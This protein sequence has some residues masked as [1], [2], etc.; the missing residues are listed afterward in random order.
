MKRVFRKILSGITALAV[1]WTNSAYLHTAGV[2]EIDS[3]P[4]IAKQNRLS[5]PSDA[6]VGLS[7]PL[8][9]SIIGQDLR[10]FDD[11]TA[12][13]ASE[14]I[15]ESVAFASTELPA[16]YSLRDAGKITSVKNQGTYGTCWT[17][18]S[19]ASAETSI[20]RYEP[21]VNLSEWHTAFFSYYGEDQMDI[22]DLST[23]DVLQYGGNCFTVANLWAQWKGPVIDSKLPYG[24]VEMLEDT[25]IREKYASDSDYHLRNAYMFDYAEDGSNRETIN[26]L[27]KQFIYSGSAVDVSFSTNGYYSVTNS[28]YSTTP[29]ILAD[30]SV[31]IAGWD[32]NFSADSFR[33][34]NKPSSDGA[35]LVR[36]SWDTGWGDNGY[37]WISYED[38]SLTEFSVFELDSKEKYSTNYYYD[39]FYPAALMAAD[40]S[41]AEGT[42]SYMANVF[43][44]E[45]TQQIEAVSTYINVPGT[46][47]EVT[48]YTGLRDSADPDSGTASSVTKGSSDITGYITIELDEDVIVNE[49]EA[50]AVCVKLVS[51]ESAYVLPHEACLVLIDSTTGETTLLT[52]YV[53]YERICENTNTGESFYSGDGDSWT[54]MVEKNQEYTEEEKNELVES[55]ISANADYMTEEDIAA[56]RELFASGDLLMIFGN[57]SVK[58][59]AN[60]V[61]TIDFSHMSGNVPLDEKVSLS[62]KDGSD[63]YYSV[64]GGAEILYTEP[65]TVTE[66][67]KIQA[68]TDHRSYTVREYTPAKAEFIDL[69]YFTTYKYSNGNDIIYAQRV[70]ESEYR[71]NLSGGESSIKLFA[72]SEAD[73]LMNG[74]AMT[75]NEYTENFSAGYGETVI[76]FTLTQENRLD[77]TVTL[78][79]DRSPVSIDIETETVTLNEA[80]QLTAPDGHVFADGESVSEYAGQTL[81]AVVGTETIEV[82]VPERAVLPELEIDYYNETLNFI[83]NN[84]AELTEYA[85]M[86]EPAESDYISAE[87]RFIDGQNITSGKIMNKAFRMIPGET[88]TLRVAPGNGCF[89][90]EAETFVIPKAPQAPTEEPVYSVEGDTIVLEYSDVL[91]YGAYT[92]PLTAEELEDLASDFGYSAEEYTALMLER[93]GITSET[94]LLA[95]L[96]AEWDAVFEYSAS[97]GAVTI[98]VR[99]Y[100]TYDTFASGVKYSELKANTEN[101]IGDS[102]GDGNITAVDAA[103][104]LSY[105]AEKA[106]TGAAELTQ[107]QFERYDYNCDGQITAVDAAMILSTYAENATK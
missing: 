15:T 24:E 87:A 79:I 42:P 53:T 57:M 25:A 52:D 83:P 77:N 46:E 69:G 101:I 9:R 60:P 92:A 16:A 84:T 40:D 19:A 72:V 49:G 37:F 93:Y 103:I 107:E 14:P 74:T 76:E 20:L 21:S 55:I 6:G 33:S 11:L 50:F 12:R 26:E 28:T 36:N 34:T 61:D 102:N 90:S 75:K 99:S 105:Y 94:E 95:L 97:N 13:A 54:D 38:T 44:A 32:D 65:I 82:K 29:P 100:S 64:N 31:T 91:E 22:G 89:G 104:V 45:E 17:F 56:Y 71:I 47:Y 2:S 51:D 35:W 80:E 30:H 41:A 8:F 78:V 5:M 67:M 106:T 23:T 4:V 58:A 81:T 39:T 63:I 86:A 27:I 66:D 7:M 96:G 18:A 98:P 73:I 59:F 1:I 3:T 48:V 62:V 10:S 88:V 70:N 68:T 43:T 85:V